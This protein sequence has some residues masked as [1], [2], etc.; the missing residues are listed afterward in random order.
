MNGWCTALLYSRYFSSIW[1]IKNI[2]SI[3]DLLRRNSHW[4]SPIIS[5]THGLPDEVIAFFKWPNTS[6]LT[7]SLGSTQPLTE[8]SIR[9]LPGDKERPARKADSL[10]AI[11]ELIVYKMWEPRRLTII[12]SWRS[13]TGIALLLH[14]DLASR[15]GYWIKFWMTLIIN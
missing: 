6:S 7:M 14:M 9:D 3:I 4:W 10:T 8:M 15:E 12:C 1:R 2:G 13:V 5:S 11:C